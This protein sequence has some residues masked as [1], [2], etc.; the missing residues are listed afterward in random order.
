MNRKKFIKRMG[1]LAVCAACMLPARAAI[2]GAA[3]EKQA[4]SFSVCTEKIMYE[5]PYMLNGYT[6]GG[7]GIYVNPMDVRATDRIL[8]AINEIGIANTMTDYDKVAAVNEYLCK[9]L[10]YADYAADADYP[11]ERDWL[12]FTDYCLLSRWAV[13]AGYAEAFQSLCCT[14][15]IECWYVTGYVFQNG[16]DDGVYHAWNSVMLEGRKYYIDVCWN[17]GSQNAYFL[18]EKGWENHKVETEHEVYRINAQEFPM[19]DYIMCG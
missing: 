8:D 17:D 15:G 7:A 3:L 4:V 9:R 14:L 6:S 5:R 12:P 19:P 16:S 2:K 13:C 10:D 18:S 11:Y 1:V